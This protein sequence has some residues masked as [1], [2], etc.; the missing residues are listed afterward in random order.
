M[1]LSI[2]NKQI[3]LV[4]VFFS[5]IFGFHQITAKAQTA[6]EIWATWKAESYIPADFKGKAMPSDSTLVT[7]SFEVTEGGRFINLSSYEIYWYLNSELIKTA[8]GEQQV[9]FRVP[10][11]GNHQLMIKVNDYEGRTLVKTI[12]IPAVRPE[13]VIIAPYPRDIFSNSQL[14]VRAVPYFFNTTNPASLNFSWAVNGQRPASTENISF[15]NINL[16]GQTADGYQLDIRLSVSD[17]KDSLSMAAT[18]KSLF[19]RK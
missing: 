11:R 17:P 9:A 2:F 12:T 19:F 4:A 10:I 15:L 18:A 14:Q 6:P 5:L 8:T 16:G 13:A 7:A 3:F 1:I